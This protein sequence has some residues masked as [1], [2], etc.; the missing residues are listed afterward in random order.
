MRKYGLLV[1]LMLAVF[2]FSATAR[3]GSFIDSLT[4]VTVPDQDDCIERV[5]AGDLT[6]HGY[7]VTGGSVH[8]LDEAG[9]PYNKAF[10]GY[11]GILYNIPR[12]F[13]DGRFNPLGD[14]IIRQA[15]QK[16]CDKEL[17]ASEFLLNNALPMYSS[18]LPTAA[19]YPSII[20]ATTKTKIAFAFDEELGL[21]MI[22]DRMLEI[23]GV[24]NADGN[25]TILND[26]SGEMQVIEVIGTIRLSDERHELGDYFCDQLEKAGFTTRRIYGSGGD[27]GNYWQ[28]TVPGE[29]AWSF[30][31]EGWGSSGISLESASTWA[32]MFTDMA[33]PVFPY[34]EMTEEWC[35][36]QFGPDFYQAASDIYQGNY[37]SAEERLDMFRICEAGF[38]ENPTHVWAW[39]N[40]SAYMIPENV[41]VIHDLAAGTFI[42][43]FVGH[44]LR[45]LDADGAPIMGGDMVVS[46]Q[47]FL[48][49]PINPIDGS[50]W[51]YD[52]MFMRPTQDFP[53]YTHP[54]TGISFPHMVDSVDV[55]VLE[56]KPVVI[57]S[58]TVEDG[59]C[60]LTFSDFIE[61]P[62]DA[63]GDWDAENQVFIPISEIYPDG[64]MDCAA[65][66][67]ITYPAWLLD[68]ESFVWHD[69]SPFSLADMVNGLIVGFP[70][71]LA[72]PESEIYDEYKV[73]SYDAGMGTF[74]GVKI[75]ATEPNLVVEVYSTAISLYAESIANGNAATLWPNSNNQS[76]T[77]AWHQFALGYMTERDGLGT[78]GSSKAA[79]LGVD[80]ISYVDGPQLQLLLGNLGT[81][82]F[83]NFL[84]YA[85]TL[86]QYVTTEEIIARYQNLSEFAAEYSHL[87]IGTGPMILSQVDTL[88]GITVLINN[89]DY[90]YEAGYYLG[91]GFDTVGIPDV[92][93]SGPDTV[94]IGDAV[95]FDVAIMLDGEA[96][97]AANIKE[98]IYLLIDASG[99]IA[100]DGP[101]AI[102]GDGAATVTLTADQT[103]TLSSGANRMEI[104]VVVKTVVLP[105]ST[106]ISFTTL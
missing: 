29:G 66:S 8:L 101:G 89:P 44:S 32:Q 25:W 55:V 39:N 22:N 21:Q 4:Y 71:D 7:Q 74:R 94:N 95:T 34:S 13:N 40:A 30:Y 88:A 104:V 51:T 38:R 79:E 12:I 45:F 63:W 23:G 52:Y 56:G 85:P 103:A 26:V 81:A 37:S 76:Y 67:T 48:T 73:S 90:V 58:T 78:F 35:T 59:W 9:I 100:Y 50:N 3:Q 17:W 57:D 54:H 82:V 105:G 18:V 60:T 93:A 68:G 87:W 11:R 5:I 14:K 102:A 84:P 41:S 1:C 24:K 80:W 77:P 69:G 31:T 91:R 2:A 43:S 83:E 47:D 20:V 42:H 10:S 70:F 19:T 86:S 49:D 65:K 97:P 106:Q 6:L 15:L 53:C 16:L 98:V 33:L 75:V 36:E 28:G 46:N 99:Q 27:L 96:Y 72:K 61:V 92:S 64:V 62:G